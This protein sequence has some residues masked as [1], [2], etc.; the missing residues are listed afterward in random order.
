MAGIAGL[1]VVAHADGDGPRLVF[2]PSASIT[3]SCKPPLP[4]EAEA[5]RPAFPVAPAS[6]ELESVPGGASR[7]APDPG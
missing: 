1:L 2:G 6:R 3:P 4:Q 7:L 5:P